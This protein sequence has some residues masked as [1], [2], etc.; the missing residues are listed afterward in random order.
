MG[1]SRGETSGHGAS[2]TV[3]TEVTVER[4][5]TIVLV[6]NVASGASETCPLC[7]H[8]P[9]SEHSA[10]VRGSLAAGPGSPSGPAM[11]GGSPVTANRDDRGTG[12]AAAP[13]T[14]GSAQLDSSGPEEGR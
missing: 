12:C 5:E 14:G 11:P 2:R 3:R 13:A 7:G 8:K 6:G 1:F 9:A 10:M 4:E